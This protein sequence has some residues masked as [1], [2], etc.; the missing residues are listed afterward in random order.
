MLR[1]LRSSIRGSRRQPSDPHQ[2]TSAKDALWNSMELNVGPW[3][4][5]WK[6]TVKTSKIFI[7]TSVFKWEHTSDHTHMTDS[8]RPHIRCKYVDC[9]CCFVCEILWCSVRNGAASRNFVRQT[10]FGHCKVKPN[11]PTSNDRIVLRHFPV[12][13]PCA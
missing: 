12:S 4:C 10:V 5:V 7:A 8:Q 1:R 13:R 9:F 11:L 2:S 6:Q 3:F